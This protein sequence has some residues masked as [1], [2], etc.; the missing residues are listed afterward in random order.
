MKLQILILIFFFA[1]NLFAQDLV[2]WRGSNR[3]GIYPEQNLLKS[4]P[5]NG[6]QLLLELNDVGNGY[7]SPVVYKNT[8]YVTGRKDTL[9]VISAYGM[10]GKKKWETP[11]GRAWARTYPE[12]RCTPTIE[13]DRIYLISGLGEVVCVEA[14]SGKIMWTVDANKIYN[15]EPHRWGVAESPAVS[16]KAVFYVTGGDETTVVA[17]DKTNGKLLWKT[18]SLGGARAYASSLLIEKAGMQI[19][20]AQTAND[21]IGINIE[22]G[23]I[24]WTYNLIQYH[25]I[26]Q[27]K[28]A[29]TN[30]PLVYKNEIFVTSGYDHAAVMLTLSGDG[31][32]VKLKWINPDFDSHM[33][34]AVKIGNHIFGS[35]WKNNSSGNWVCVDW[36][37]GKTMYDTHWHNKGSIISADGML[38][39]YE[40]KSG[41]L[42]LV[43]PDPEKF[44]IV[45]SFKIEKGIGPHWTHPAIFDGKLYVRHGEY[46]AV[47][48]LKN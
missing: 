40:E 16:D 42:A 25:I 15:G 14:G 17:L 5:E 48:N 18:K 28:G 11:Y 27:G 31:H 30:T 45:S 41:N 47:Y 6:P 33:G 10:N 20:L 29:N 35:N 3:S 32:S 26:Q 9:D 12:T 7:S 22:N 2:E 1:G 8:I 34:G 13:N 23:E 4:W 38:Y 21:L 46:L 37:T 19:L 39:C 36:E 44:E 24:L 43:K